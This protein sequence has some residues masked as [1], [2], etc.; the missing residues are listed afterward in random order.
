MKKWKA[1]KVKQE[2]VDQVKEEVK[3]SKYKNLSEFVSDAIRHRLQTLAKQR[4]SEYLERDRI[5]KS[6]QSEA[7]LFYTPKHIWAQMA[8]QGNIEVGITDYFQNQLKEIVN[9]RTDAVGENVFKDEPF[10][11]AESWWFT[12]D[13]YS[14]VNGKIVAVNKKVVDDPFIL[15]VDPFLWIV[16]VQPESTEVDS[17][18]RGLLSLEEYQKMLT[19]RHMPSLVSS[20]TN[21]EFWR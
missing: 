8:P 21:K 20:L 6:L 4:V 14:P 12:Y 11:V 2:L 5:I 13:L 17:W 16:K 1:V 3:K 18:R 7:Q 10:G 19:K 9:I 15:N